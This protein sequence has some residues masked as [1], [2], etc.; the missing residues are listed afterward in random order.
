MKMYR[1]NIY[2]TPSECPEL[3]PG[4]VPGAFDLTALIE[5]GNYKV[6]KLQTSH[7]FYG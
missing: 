4:P 3:Y 1:H 7:T 6:A 2:K 5:T